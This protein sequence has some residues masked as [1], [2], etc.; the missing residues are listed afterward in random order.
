MYESRMFEPGEHSSADYEFNL[1]LSDMQK[2]KGFK[3]LS[4]TS[5]YNDYGYKKGLNIFVCYEIA[6]KEKK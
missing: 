5:F 6:K 1:F 2:L 4:I 3:I